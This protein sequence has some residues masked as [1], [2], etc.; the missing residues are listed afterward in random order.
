MGAM[1]YKKVPEITA[2][3]WI[4]KILTTAMGESTSDYLVSHMD[5]VI[6]VMLG[7]LGLIVALA[8]QFSVRRYVAWVYWLCVVMVAIFG[9]MAADVL[10]I[11]LG[12]PYVVSTTF[13][14]LALVI[15]FAAWYA[16]EKTLS[17][18]SIYTRRR[19]MFYWLTV[20]ATFALGT[21]LGDMTATTLGLGYLSSGILFIVLIVVVAI[22]HYITKGILSAEHRHLSRNAVLAF[23]LAYILTRP[24]GASFADWMGKA[25]SVGGLGWGDGSVSVVLSVIILCFVGYLSITRVDVEEERRVL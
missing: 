2:Y 23:W 21:A 4:I 8:L 9:T 12:V 25:H 22:A 6:A 3:F 19:E 7:A 15:I 1:L 24:L 10:H 14:F 20:M 17:I 16:S 5:P 11:G 18:H 13:F